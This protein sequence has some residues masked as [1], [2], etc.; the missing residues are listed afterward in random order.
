ATK[1][2]WHSYASLASGPTANFQGSPTSGAAPLTVA[3]TDTSTGAPTSWSWSFGDGGTSTL[4]SP[5]HVYQS[6][7]TYTVSLS[8]ANAAG[9]NTLTRSAYISASGPPPTANFQ[10]SPTT[11]PAPLSVA[12]TDTSTGAPTGW[13]WS[14]GDGGTSTAQNPTHVY[15]SPGTYSVA[16]TASNGGG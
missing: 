8:V 12:F 9:S 15:Q 1:R 6:P 16:L 4:Q 10:G 11:G 14:F 2:Y 5:G 7:G 3:F 13:S